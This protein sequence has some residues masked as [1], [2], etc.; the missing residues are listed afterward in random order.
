[1]PALPDYLC[2]GIDCFIGEML[3]LQEGISHL[4]FQHHY[5]MDNVIYWQ[6]LVKVKAH[7]RGHFLCRKKGR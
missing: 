5:S 4:L 3:H 1:V 7:E 2:G 6:V